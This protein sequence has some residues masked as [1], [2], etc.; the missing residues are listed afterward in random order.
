MGRINWIN[1]ED[2]DV[3]GLSKRDL[4]LFRVKFEGCPF[5]NYAIGYYVSDSDIFMLWYNRYNRSFHGEW[6]DCCGFMVNLPSRYGLAKGAKKCGEIALLEDVISN[7]DR[8]YSSSVPE[9][10]NENYLVLTEGNQL[11][12]TRVSSFVTGNNFV[13]SKMVDLGGNALPWVSELEEKVEWYI[14]L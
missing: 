6:F 1:A 11:L 9:G 14:R 13:V 2:F 12:Q 5:E 10:Y 4:L 7:G 8:V 3:S